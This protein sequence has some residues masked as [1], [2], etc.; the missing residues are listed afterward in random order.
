MR[1]MFSLLGLLLV[2]ALIAHLARLEL[3]G[4]AAPRAG[5]SAPITPQAYKQL[6]DKAVAA[7]HPGEAGSAP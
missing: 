3:R 4:G 7:S 6:L 5:A 1:L 2:L